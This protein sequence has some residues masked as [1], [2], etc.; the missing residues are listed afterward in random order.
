MAKVAVNVEGAVEA[1]KQ[2]V[3]QQ[4]VRASLVRTDGQLARREKRQYSVIPSATGTE[5]KLVSFQ[6]E[7][8]K[9]KQTLTYSEPLTEHQDAGIDGELIQD[10]TEDLVSD[11][12]SRDGIPHEL[13]PNSQNT[14]T[15]W[16][17]FS[18]MD[19]EDE[20]NHMRAAF[21]LRYWIGQSGTPA[22]E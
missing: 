3:Y 21:G 9:G 11:K 18:M 10:L 19:I 17:R 6:G 15:Q 1:R 12:R 4:T 22:A 7:Y 8:W 5:K 14:R 20:H 13:F 16:P 2:Y